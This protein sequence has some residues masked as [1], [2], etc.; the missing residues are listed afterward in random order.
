M[1][2]RLS[3]LTLASLVAACGAHPPATQPPEEIA[4][5][6]GSFDAGELPAPAATA[7]PEAVAP[8]AGAA[9]PAPAAPEV[10][11][12]SNADQDKAKSKFDA[13]AQK[14]AAGDVDG[15]IEGFNSAFDENPR[16]AWAA[17]NVG[18]LYERKALTDKAAE[19]Y[20]AALRSKPDFEEASANL[21]RLRLRTGQFSVA[22]HELRDRIGH[23]PTVLG[24]R[25]QYVEVL[26]AMGALDRGETEE[27][28]VLKL[29][30]RN[31][32]AMLNLAII[33][34][35]QKKYELAR[36]ILAEN[37]AAI[38]PGNPEI[39]NTLG[40]VYLGLKSKPQALEAFKK[41]AA[42]RA[43]FPEAH[44]NLGTF[45]NEASDW[46]DSVRELELA[47][48]YA[49]DWAAAHL[50][51]GNAYRG[52]KQYDKALAEYNKA[53]EL[54]PKNPDPYFNLGL[55]YLDGDFKDKATLDRIR[56]A[57]AFFQQFKAGGGID[58]H[59]DA[60]VNAANTAQKK[61]LARLDNENRKKL[62][63]EAD[64]K[65]KKD[66][67]ETKERAAKEAADRLQK[68]KLNEDDD[69]GPTPGKIGAAPG[70]IKPV[71]TGKLGGDDEDAPA[72][73]S[74]APTAP[75][76]ATGKLGGDD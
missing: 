44:I 37:A 10:P 14:M 49:P 2:R 63:M 47:V 48:K 68:G 72:P 9:A 26:I 62:K 24:L 43:D 70:A 32:R 58:P 6:G 71:M 59:F 73:R 33:W 18:V 21:A 69:S 42:L 53:L 22:E 3:W 36:D 30:E 65:K 60:Y 31:A 46:P 25:N 8:D 35:K 52:N 28:R 40:F 75:P 16:L 17:Y 66:E 27:K 57:L 5:D 45:Y 13:A 76:P 7:L 12:V 64:A 41:A 19:A 15:A 51:L 11:A 56:Q 55:L 34:Y 50:N 74:T 23:F 39:Y 4:A 54:A 61:E 1:I 67:A 29:D 20:A 38:E